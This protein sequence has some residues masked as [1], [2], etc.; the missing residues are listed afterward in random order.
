MRSGKY[1]EAQV[2]LYMMLFEETFTLPDLRRILTNLP[3]DQAA[4]GRIKDE[5]ALQFRQEYGL[6]D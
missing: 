4:L 1:T 5:L 6:L 3:V 2:E